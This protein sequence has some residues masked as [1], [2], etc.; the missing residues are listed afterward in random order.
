MDG[1]GQRRTEPASEEIAEADE[2]PPVAVD[3]LTVEDDG[4]PVEN[5]S[6]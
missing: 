6:G 3:P 4:T 5:P 2:G 1:V